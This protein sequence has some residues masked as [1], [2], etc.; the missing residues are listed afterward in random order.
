[1]SEKT[2]YIVVDRAA[3]W[4]QVLTL[5]RGDHLP[6]GGIL[7]WETQSDRVPRHVFPDRASA[8]AAITRTDH[9]RLAFERPYSWPEKANC[10]ILAIRLP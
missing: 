6:L 10:K 8:R 2:A 3:E 7:D 1:M 9:Y 4:E 5:R